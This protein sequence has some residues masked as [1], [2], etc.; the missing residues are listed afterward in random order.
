MTIE[1]AAQAQTQRR[2]TQ[3][4][5]DT[6]RQRPAGL[7]VVAVAEH[8]WRVSDPT[9]AELGSIPLIGFVREIDHLFEVTRLG[10]PLERLR[11]ESLAMAISYLRWPESSSA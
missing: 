5:D 7:E 2:P 11:F 10:C 6:S 9:R 4:A 1:T 3:S 8:E